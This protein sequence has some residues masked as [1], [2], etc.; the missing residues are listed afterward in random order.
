MGKNNNVW[1]RYFRDKRRFADLFNGVCF[2]GKQ[3]LRPEYL[4]E[5]SEVYE[6]IGGTELVSSDNKKVASGIRD[7]KM[8]YG[9]KEIFRLLAVEDQDT[10]DY[11][12]AFRCM[13][14]DTMEYGRQL[15]DL[16]KKNEAKGDYANWDE[17]ICRMKKSDRLIPVYTLCLYHG[18]RKWDG[19]RSL[20]D[21]MD[22]GD[23][24]DGMSSL[25]VDYKFLLFC[26]NEEADLN[27]FRT[28]IKQLFQILR[29]RKNKKGLRQVMAENPEYMHMD[30]DTME[31][32]AVALNAPY[33]WEEREQYMNSEE[34]EGY[35][36]CQALEEW[37]EEERTEGFA[38]GVKQ[39]L[40]DMVCIKLRKGKTAD[41]IAEE[42]EEPVLVIQ[43]MCEVAE[44]YAPDYNCDDV[45]TALYGKRKRSTMEDLL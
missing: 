5:G 1:V 28:E 15:D 43:N 11:S 36:M 32:A 13:R 10:V 44:K 30:A 7:I 38:E 39:K 12:M 2:Q 23:D 42:L 40:V 31:V 9:D 17:K 20:K 4:T 24:E 29:Y 16:H 18:D 6:G 35:N 25:F 37:A 45:Y 19:P 22:F 26:L 21:M 41:R 8:C 3:V 33:I 27:V 34:R 14:Y